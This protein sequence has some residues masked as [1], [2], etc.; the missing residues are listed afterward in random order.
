MNDD[1]IDEL[2]GRLEAREDRIRT[3]ETRLRWLVTG[4]IVAG[5]LGTPGW[6]LASTIT[7]PNLFT[8]GQV[9]DADDI[10]ENFGVLA[11]EATRVSNIVIGDA[12]SGG[13]RVVGLDAPVSGTDAASKDYVDAAVGASGGSGSASIELWGATS[14]PAG[15][16]TA[17]QGTMIAYSGTG[18]TNLDPVCLHSSLVQNSSDLPGDSNWL[19]VRR[20]ANGSPTYIGNR[21][22]PLTSDNQPASCV[23]C[24]R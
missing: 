5:V 2:L 12:A 13:A 23:I 7:V 4:A 17:L 24:V 3:R 16:D 6:L 8:N 21:N 11:T 1:R 15:W 20:T 14:C 19:M 18:V 22:A 10:N 9:A